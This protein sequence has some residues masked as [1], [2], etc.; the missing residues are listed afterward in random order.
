MIS[1]FQASPRGEERQAVSAEHA[2]R[3]LPHSGQEEPEEVKRY[4]PSSLG[5]R[6]ELMK[7]VF[8]ILNVTTE[9]V[10]YVKCELVPIH[11]II[12]YKYNKKFFQI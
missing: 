1:V 4:G 3:L 10:E 2:A 9:L 8:S 11:L 6:E 5:R 7:V 12:K